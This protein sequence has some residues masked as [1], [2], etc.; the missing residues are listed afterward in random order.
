MLFIMWFKYGVYVITF[1]A[2]LVYLLLFAGH[3]FEVNDIDNAYFNFAAVAVE[4][5]ADTALVDARQAL[6]QAVQA[7]SCSG[8][9]Q[10]CLL[11]SKLYAE[12]DAQQKAH[13][14][15]KAS[16]EIAQNCNSSYE[17]AQSLE[18]AGNYFYRVLGQ[19]DTA[20]VIMRQ[21]HALAVANHHLRYVAI[22]RHQL[23]IIYEKLGSY[24]Q[25]A[26]SY[27][28][29]IEAYHST[30]DTLGAARLAVSLG[31]LLTQ[32]GQ[33]DAALAQLNA[34]VPRLTQLGEM[35]AAAMAML[36][37]GIA[38]KDLQYFDLAAQHLYAAL[39]LAEAA[40]ATRL[41]ARL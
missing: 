17:L 12:R 34:A 21:S 26:D 8:Q 20:L 14:A 29:A 6:V 40:N 41:Q 7:N 5:P 9:V 3:A 28:L 2:A 10:A 11:F 16:V 30:D 39:P 36:N 38:F 22:T 15:L 13:E 32:Q 27:A 33:Y 1:M 35:K 25:A 24:D 37:A 19:Y 31:S 23:G 4:T 18:R